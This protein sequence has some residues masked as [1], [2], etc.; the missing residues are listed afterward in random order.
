MAVTTPDSTTSSNVST[1]DKESWVMRAGIILAGLF[2]LVAIILPL[3]TMLSKSF[4]DHDGGYIGLANF[5]KYFSTPALFYSIENSLTVA[6]IA[7][8]I[9]SL[10]AFFFAYSLTRTCVKFKGFFKIIALAPLLA[11]S[12]L[13]AIS[14]VYMFGKKGYMRDVLLGESIYG[15]IG[16]VL[17][18]A[19]WTFPH[20][21]LIM[22][23]ALSI[24]DARL[25]EAAAA[26][27]TSKMR[28]FFTVTLPGAKYGLIS[29]VIVVFTLVITDFGVPK[30]IGG[31]YNVL[32]TDIYKQVIG[33]QNFQMGAVVSMVL[34]IPAIVAFTIDR[35]VQ[36]RQVA[37]LSARA[38]PYAPSPMK[39]RD[40]A[41]LIYCSI[42]TIMILLV[43][44]TAAYAS[45]ITFWPYNLSFTLDNYNFNVMDGGGWEAWRNSIKLG[46]WTAAIG[47]I[48]VF[49]VAYLVE[50]GR[51][52]GS[53]RLL[54]QMMAMIPL[55]V[56]GLVLGLSYIF[57]FNNPAN[58]F[59]FIYGTMI[60]LVVSTVAHFYTVTHLTATTALKQMDIEFE[61][62]SSSL[63]VPFWRTFARVTVP[64][65]QPALF[66]MAVYLF[67][68]A[69]TTVS[70]VVFLYSP[71]TTLASVAVMNMDDAGDIAP[72]AAMA[73]VIVA[74]N[75]VVIILHTLLSRWV[76]KRTQAWRKR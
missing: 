59:N 12:L 26:L 71:E 48:L 60:I 2:L 21:M 5:E 36:R 64:V 28:T 40:L 68:N 61:A 7:T 20:A 30:V 11:P 51:G 65:C 18:S 31:K 23:T 39:G 58:P 19:F 1:F 8:T 38:V 53:G 52:F 3:Y 25:Y 33:Q 35:I 27:R 24:S 43:L 29:A 44:G 56:P 9:V 42:I 49:T 32:A 45:F 74:T 22:I 46:A 34:L 55:A 17:G 41:A 6:V 73:M 62:V 50:K 67:M 4:E 16:I 70:A 66:S 37:L 63:K 14:F 75:I 54:I 76:E 72:A 57:F 69:M 10:L 15:P 47:S 13:P